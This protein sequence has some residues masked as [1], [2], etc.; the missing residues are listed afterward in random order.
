MP[1][2]KLAI[3]PDYDPLT[4]ITNPP[5]DESPEQRRNRLDAEQRAKKISDSI[6]DEINRER[7][8]QRKSPR[9]VKLLLLGMSTLNV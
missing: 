2:H 9:P 3:N 1:A 6:D 4:I 5:N 8:A 7:I